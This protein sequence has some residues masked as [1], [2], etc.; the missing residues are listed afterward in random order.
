MRR[1]FGYAGAS[2]LVVL[3]AGCG[4]AVEGSGGA[5]SQEEGAGGAPELPAGVRE[6]AAA[7]GAAPELIYSVQ[8]PGHA[9][10]EQSAG[11]YGED[12]YQAAYTSG[13]DIVW[14]T[15]TRGTVTGEEDCVRL[16]TVNGG[17]AAAD[18]AVTCEQDANGWYR[19]SGD[20][21]EY[22]VVH[23]D[24]VVRLDADRDSV[25]RDALASAAAGAAPAQPTDG[26][27]PTGGAVEAPGGPESP[28]ERGDL[29]EHGD[30][31]PDNSV[32]V[33]G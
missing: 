27:E 25:D 5:A 1:I 33:G 28:V 11:V 32:G 26:E 19:T 9:L 21:H 8:L 24:H 13:G 6:G 16:P 2:A 14:L 17:V 3:L 10:A 12:G 29:P 31:A 30:G 15:V 23:G 4:Q 22:V 18:S 20:R 7:Q